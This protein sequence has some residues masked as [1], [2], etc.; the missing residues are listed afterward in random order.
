MHALIKMAQKHILN[1]LSCIDHDFYVLMYKISI[2][3]Q[4]SRVVNIF[5]NFRP[6]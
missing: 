2:V 4:I 5:E 6:D 1:L 3:A